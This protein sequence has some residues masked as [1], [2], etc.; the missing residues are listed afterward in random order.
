MEMIQNLR[1]VFSHQDMIILTGLFIIVVYLI[2]PIQKYNKTIAY[3]IV[4]A[5]CLWWIILV[6]IYPPKG[7]NYKI[8]RYN[9]ALTISGQK[10]F[11]R[12]DNYQYKKGDAAS[13]TDAKYLDYTGAQHFV[14]VLMAEFSFSQINSKFQGLGFQLWTILI[15]S[16]I[17]LLI[18]Y[19][20]DFSNESIESGKLW[21]IIF[22]SFLPIISFYN[23]IA[24]WEDKLIFLLIPLLLLLL[25]KRKKLRIAS[26]II[27][28]VIS[29]NGATVF[30]LP[31]YLIYL[32][33][34][35]KENIWQNILL[36]FA[37]VIIAL[38]PYFPESLN[39]WTNRMIRMDITKPFWYSFYSLLPSGI[40]SPL[41]NNII[42]IVISLLTMVLFYYK[43]INIIDALIISISIVIMFSP[44]NGVSRVIPLILLLAIMTPNMKRINWILLGIFLF[45]F[46]T[47]DN[48]YITPVVN[49]ENTILFYIPVLFSFGLYIYKRLKYDNINVLMAD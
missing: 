36:M 48:G 8:Y 9:A 32:F 33:Q 38:I 10:A 15:I 31:V 23:I 22:I 35:N 6:F 12:V 2:F 16:T 17:I 28:L 39:G 19:L 1:F 27:G 7:N 30:F 13:Y 46:L 40:Y 5:C 41:L 21:P 26:F 25:I 44:Y 14:Y 34:E 24:S 42:I 29:Y 20:M 49:T 11:G 45:I 43:K 37:G 47:F 3:R 18:S 4:A